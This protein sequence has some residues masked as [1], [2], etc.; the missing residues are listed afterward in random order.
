MTYSLHCVA[1]GALMSRFRLLKSIIC[2]L[3]V[4][5]PAAILLA[6]PLRWRIC[7]SACSRVM[8]GFGVKGEGEAAS[9]MVVVTVWVV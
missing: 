2:F 4:V 9:G 8:V 3:G 7:S 6:L 5:C 1:A